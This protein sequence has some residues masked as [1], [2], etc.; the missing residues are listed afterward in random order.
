[1]STRDPGMPSTKVRGRHKRQPLEEVIEY[2][3]TRS[4]GGK[5]AR[6]HSLQATMIADMAIG[7]ESARAYYMSVA[8]MFDNRR[9][10][11]ENACMHACDMCE[12]I[13]NQATELTGC[14]GYST[15]A[16]IEKYLRDTKIM[17]L[18]LGGA[19][20]GRLDVVPSLYP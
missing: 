8:K 4:C 20:L 2:T 13:C 18:W 5:P 7:I 9:E 12:M 17:Q 19:Q 15:Q 10:Y 6:N 14:Y 16:P 11:G 3:G 1:M